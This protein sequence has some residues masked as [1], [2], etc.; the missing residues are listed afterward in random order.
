MAEIRIM[1]RKNV[2]QYQFEIAPVNGTRKYINKSG[3]KT[4]AEALEAGNVAYTEY[5]NA[6]KPFRESKLSYSDY[7]DYWLNNYCKSNLK[8]NTIEAYKVLIEKYIKP[9]LGKYKL[10]TL[11]SVALN[12]FI[13]EI[14]NEYDFSREYFKNILKVIKGS[15]REACNLYGIIKYNPS[16]TIRLPKIDKLNRFSKHLYTLEEIEQILERFKD[17]ATFL[18]AFITSCYTGMRTG[19][20]FALTWDDIDFENGLL[21]IKHNVYDKPK[22]KFGRWYIGSTKTINGIRT[23]YLSDTLLNALLNFKNRQDYLKKIYGKDYKYYHL[24]EVKNEYGKVVEQRIVLNKLN[25]EKLNLIFTKDDGTYMGTDLIR[26]PFKLI[27]KELGIEK[28]RF[29]DLRG[30]YAT[31]ILNNGT[32]IKDVAK[33]L[34]HSNTLTTE[35]YYIT[36]LD[37][38]RKIAVQLFDKN[39]SSETIKNVIKFDIKST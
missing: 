2:F 6:G 5:I 28:C 9:K 10:S 21:N 8:Y 39:N 19:E 11:T 24:E 22:D 18:L 7:L 27:H 36:S 23:I 26:Y 31:R 16:I 35:N 38:N 1:K 37:E 25:E 13:I 20:V 33:L 32:E 12:N 34:G 3:F 17:N 15:F 14:T 30:T 4:K 29:Y